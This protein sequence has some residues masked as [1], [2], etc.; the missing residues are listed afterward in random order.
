MPKQM[1]QDKLSLLIDK[2][3]VV[4][5]IGYALIAV[6]LILLLFLGATPGLSPPWVGL[7][8]YLLLGVGVI[9]VFCHKGIEIIQHSRLRKHK[10][11]CMSCGWFGRG[12]DWYRSGCC[13]ECDSEAVTL[14]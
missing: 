4:K 1:S 13:P 5:Q 2:A 12:D 11:Y 8:S 7:Y 14:L 9:L 10:A 6:A 3:A